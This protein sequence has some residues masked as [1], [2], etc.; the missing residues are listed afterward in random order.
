MDEAFEIVKKLDKDEFEIWFISYGGRSKE[1]YKYDRFFQKV[2]YYEMPTIYRSCDILLKT[3][4]LES[5][6]YPPL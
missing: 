4:S 1:W 5:F 2:P 3:S 6:S